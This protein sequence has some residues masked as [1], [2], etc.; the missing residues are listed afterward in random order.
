MLCFQTGNGKGILRISILQTCFHAICLPSSSIVNKFVILSFI[1]NPYRKQRIIYNLK[2]MGTKKV[3]KILI[4]ISELVTLTSCN[5]MKIEG[6]WVESIPEMTNIHQGFTL[7]STGK[8][9]SIHMATLQYETWKRQ[10]DLLILSGKSIGNRQTIIFSDT[11]KIEKL[12]QD[13]LILKKGELILK[14]TKLKKDQKSIP[15]SVITPAKKIL[16]VKGI[17]EIGHEV[18]SF[19]A[20][21]DSV[22]HWIIDETKELIPKYDEL[23]KGTKNATPVYVELEVV[24]M[25]KS[26]EGFAANYASIYQVIKINKINK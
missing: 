16:S 13:S 2:I 23:T 20:T 12:S 3:F 18:R 24:D 1:K 15:A 7:E 10:N 11:L 9:S 8:A 26:N 19:T 25:G 14:Y 21:G 5:N 17:L 22:S 4:I 6:S